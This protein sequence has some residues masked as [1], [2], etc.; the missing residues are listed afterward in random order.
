MALTDLCS[1]LFK[2]GS[3]ESDLVPNAGAGAPAVLCECGRRA[4]GNGGVRLEKRGAMESKC[5]AARSSQYEGTA[6]LMQERERLLSM[7]IVGG[8]PTR[9]GVAAELHASRRLVRCPAWGEAGGSQ[10]LLCC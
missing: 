5:S 3:Q 8:G 2:K 7:V 10:Q 1:L 4:D 6:V 9:V